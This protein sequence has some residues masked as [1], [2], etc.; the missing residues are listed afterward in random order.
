MKELILPFLLVL[1]L[2]ASY[3]RE[4]LA[5]TAV[6]GAAGGYILRDEGYKVQSSIKKE[7]SESTHEE[8]NQ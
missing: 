7:T 5:G 4:F 2:L 8:T 1:A 3:G 6:G